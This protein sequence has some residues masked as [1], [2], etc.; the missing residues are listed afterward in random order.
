MDGTGRQV[1]I[2]SGIKWPNGL[3]LDLTKKKLYWADA[4]TDKIEQSNFDG[5][6]RTTIIGGSNTDI[7]PFGL[8]LRQG[9]LYWTDW[10][11]KAVMGVNM[12]SGR[13]FT[14]VKGLSHPTGIHVYDPNDKPAG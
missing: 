13:N 9:I 5:S 10:R 11:E 4:S 1:I 7:H 8:A 12:T 2:N 3:S 6:A 14:V